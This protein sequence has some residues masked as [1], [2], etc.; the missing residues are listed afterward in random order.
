MT[1]RFSRAMGINLAKTL[2][3]PAGAK[4]IINSAIEGDATIE[5]GG[6][7]VALH[8]N[9]GSLCDPSRTNAIGHSLVQVAAGGSLR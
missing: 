7:D 6:N 8:G 9:S 3:M 2:A 1:I 4:I 5:T